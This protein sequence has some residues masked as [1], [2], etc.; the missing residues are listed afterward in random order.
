MNSYT[1][2]KF[3]LICDSRLYTLNENIL[4]HLGED[5]S[6]IGYSS[7]EH[8]HVDVKR[9]YRYKSR[10]TGTRMQKPVHD[11]ETTLTQQQSSVKGAAPSTKEAIVQEGSCLDRSGTTVNL[12]RIFTSATEKEHFM[13]LLVPCFG[14]TK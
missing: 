9:P 11:I 10:T 8:F 7:F 5:I 14:C 12:Q 6:F 2:K 3:G 4:D 1:V 13:N